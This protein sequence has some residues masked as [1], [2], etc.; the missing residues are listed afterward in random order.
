[1]RITCQRIGRPPISTSGFGIVWVS[2]R[3]R[4]PRPPQRM[5]TGSSIG[6]NATERGASTGVQVAWLRSSS[7]PL[8]RGTRAARGPA[9]GPC[10]AR[11]RRRRVPQTIVERA[12]R[13]ACSGRA[14]PRRPRTASRPRWGRWRWR[15][16]S[17]PLRT[18]RAWPDSRFQNG[19]RSARAAVRAVAVA[20]AVPEGDAAVARALERRSS[21][22]TCGRVRCCAAPASSG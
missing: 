14:R 12:R 3:S 21:Q 11:R 22:R 15:L 17:C 13:G 2:S 5:T 1:M 8:G 16:W 4:V 18:M 19:L 20:G 10:G 7:R 9:S 6:R